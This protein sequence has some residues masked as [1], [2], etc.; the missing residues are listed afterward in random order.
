MP[1]Q[2]QL[3]SVREETLHHLCL[4]LTIEVRTR[5]GWGGREEAVSLPALTDGICRG[6]TPLA[7]LSHKFQVQVSLRSK[8]VLQSKTPSL[9][10]SLSAMLPVPLL[11]SQVSDASISAIRKKSMSIHSIHL[12]ITRHSHEGDRPD[13]T[14]EH[15]E[16]TGKS[17]IIWIPKHPLP[18]CRYT[19]MLL[20]LPS[21]R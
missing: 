17:T 10:T 7:I 8:Q 19:Y 18:C 12:C 16:T 2:I 1:P 5:G 15:Q 13:I 11:E 9:M 20:C 14:Y 6:I 21:G 4:S 3:I